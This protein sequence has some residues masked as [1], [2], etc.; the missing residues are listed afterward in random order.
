MIDRF[1]VGIQRLIANMIGVLVMFALLVGLV[2][3][4]RNNPAALQELVGKLV[5]A[6]VSLVS[7]LSDLLVR[8]L[9]QGGN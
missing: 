5:D 9:D 4:A 6:I 2:I 1:L 8:S 3:W 7:W